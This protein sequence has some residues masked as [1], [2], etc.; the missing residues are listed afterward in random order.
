MVVTRGVL[1]SRHHHDVGVGLFGPVSNHVS[2]ALLGHYMPDITLLRA[3][4]IGHLVGLVIVIL[5][6]ENRSA[7]PFVVHAVI[8]SLGKDKTAVQ[9]HADIFRRQLHRLI[10]HLSFAVQVRITVLCHHHRVGRLVEHRSSQCTLLLRLDT[11]RRN[12]VSRNVVRHDAVCGKAVH[13][14]YGYT[15][16]CPHCREAE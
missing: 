6:L 8:N 12:T 14:Q 2:L 3:D 11:V 13:G 15:V 9:I 10:F 4:V 16:L 7:Y 1:S 5:V